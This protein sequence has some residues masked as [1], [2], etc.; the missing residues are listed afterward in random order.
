M[1]N[2]PDSMGRLEVLIGDEYSSICNA[3]DAKVLRFAC[4]ALG[5]K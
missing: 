2:E 5:Y 1:K 4:A 3:S